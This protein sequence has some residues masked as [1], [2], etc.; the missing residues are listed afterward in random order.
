MN[1]FIGTRM[2]KGVSVSPVKN[3]KK[4]KEIYLI[5]RRNKL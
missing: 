4:N 5:R 1:V 3:Y 2:G